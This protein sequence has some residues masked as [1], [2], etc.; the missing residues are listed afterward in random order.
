MGQQCY[1]IIFWYPRE[2]HAYHHRRI[3]G[4]WNFTPIYCCSVGRC[5][6]D[7]MVMDTDNSIICTHCGNNIQYCYIISVALLVYSLVVS[8]FGYIKSIKSL[9]FSCI[10]LRLN[11]NVGVSS[12]VFTV[13]SCANSVNFFICS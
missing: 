11:L 10:W 5:R 1:N 6:A 8:L 12:P 3:Y 9:Y 4:C 13:K 2:Y 7:S